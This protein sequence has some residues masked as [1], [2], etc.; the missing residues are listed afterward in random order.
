MAETL[1][2]TILRPGSTSTEAAPLGDPPDPPDPS[3]LPDES[4]DAAQAL[5][6]EA[7]RRRHR[8]RVAWALLAM[9]AAV[10]TVATVW[11]RTP[12][13]ARP[14]PRDSRED[15]GTSGRAAGHDA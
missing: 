15:G 4:G 12:P 6:R 13:A 3:G 2:V 11:W 1:R 14:S 10:A 9:V 7:R 5:F 8:R